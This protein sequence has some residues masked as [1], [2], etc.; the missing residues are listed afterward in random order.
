MNAVPGLSI[1]TQA[2]AAIQNNT[3]SG[4][5][6]PAATDGVTLLAPSDAAF[7]SLFNS[8]NVSGP[9]LGDKV[10]TCVHHNSSSNRSPR[11]PATR[12]PLDSDG[13]LQDASEG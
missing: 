2:I 6:F 10:R 11:V 12:A 7:I 8:V 1:M 3:A 5:V 4:S 9:E 13:E